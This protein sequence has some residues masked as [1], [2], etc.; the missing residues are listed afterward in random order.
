MII[1]NGTIEVKCKSG[2]GIDAETGFPV[3]PEFSWGTPI[4]C[5]YLINSQNR[6][7][8]VNGEHYILAKYTVL[9]EQQPF[10]GEQVRLKDMCGN[11]VGEYSV[12]S[13]EP[14]DAVCE[15]KILI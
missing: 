12:I 2:G 8:I 5:Q 11:T 15:I 3:K 4:P 1:Q 10:C 9:I 7:G 6:Q 14:L 13:V